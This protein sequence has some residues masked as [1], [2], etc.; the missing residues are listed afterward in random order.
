MFT[1]SKKIISYLFIA[2]F[3]GFFATPAA[4]ALECDKDADGYIVIP[5]SVMKTIAPELLYTEDGSYT[6][7]EWVNFFNTYKNASLTDEEK[8]DGMNFK[9]GAEPARCDMPV[10][11]ATSNVY[12]PSKQTTPIQGSSVHPGAL[13]IPDNGIDE[14]CDSKDATLIAAIGTQKDL[15][16]LVDKTISL[17]SKI[18]VVVSIAVM[19]WGGVMYSTAAGDEAKVSK[20]R[21]A[22]IGAVIGLIVGLLAPTVVNWVAANLI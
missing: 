5:A 6:E 13:D 11:G 10:I 20:A 8:C 3:L 1:N 12:D 9:K 14:N 2:I 22:I 15:G 18:V 17:L 16:G 4:L 21:K 7:T 19:I